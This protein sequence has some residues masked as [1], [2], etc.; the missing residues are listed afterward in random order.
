MKKL[1]A[2]V[3]PGLKVKVWSAEMGKLPVTPKTT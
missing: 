1:D 3:Q 2:P